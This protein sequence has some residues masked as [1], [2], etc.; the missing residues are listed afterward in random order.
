MRVQVP[1]FLFSPSEGTRGQTEENKPPNTHVHNRSKPASVSQTGV[2]FS[3]GSACVAERTSYQ[4]QGRLQNFIT[5][6][7]TYR[8]THFVSTISIHIGA[9]LSCPAIA[10][11][12]SPLREKKNKHILPAGSLSD[13]LTALGLAWQPVK[14]G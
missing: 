10:A 5:T 6:P 13:Y 8:Q 14:G 12:F 11:I 1:N 7:F 3:M 9:P 2:C 4:V